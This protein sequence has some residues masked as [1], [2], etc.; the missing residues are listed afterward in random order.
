MRNGYREAPAKQKKSL[1]IISSNTLYCQWYQD[2]VVNS[3]CI[4][5]I[6]T[7]LQNIK[8]GVND[9]MPNNR[10]RILS[11]NGIFSARNKRR[12]DNG[13]PKKNGIE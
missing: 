1:R 2:N 10:Q 3:G 13:P 11:S 9:C 12:T 4:D 8:N 5:L 7:Y 6:N